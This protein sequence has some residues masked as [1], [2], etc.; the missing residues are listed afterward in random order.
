MTRPTM[1]TRV[2]TPVTPTIPGH[3]LTI[4]TWD[5]SHIPVMRIT[6]AILTGS[7]LATRHGT[8]HLVITAT[9]RR[10]T[11]AITIIL[12]ILPGAP[13]TV[14]APILVTVITGET[15]AVMMIRN[16]WLEM[17]KILDEN[18]LAMM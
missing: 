1:F 11:P 13:I 9:I 14:I 18:L 5:T 15:T 8:I 17:V 3:H 7:A 16:A 12:S 4:S 10:C 6:T 2:I